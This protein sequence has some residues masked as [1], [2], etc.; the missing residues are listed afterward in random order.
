MVADVPSIPMYVRPVFAISS[1][2]VKGLTAP[3]TGEGSPWN[4][5]TWT[6]R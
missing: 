3:T 2:K 4:A 5:N 1:N 6:I